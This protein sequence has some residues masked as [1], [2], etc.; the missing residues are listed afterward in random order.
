MDQQLSGA[1]SVPNLSSNRSVG[2]GDHKQHEKHKHKFGFNLAKVFKKNKLGKKN[3]TGKLS[4]PSSPSVSNS[5]LPSTSSVGSSDRSSSPPHSPVPDTTARL[6]DAKTSSHGSPAVTFKV[7]EDELKKKFDT[8]DQQPTMASATTVAPA[9]GD[10]VPLEDKTS[11]L[12]QEKVNDAATE[13]AVV[14]FAG[15]N[16]FC[17]CDC[18]SP[19]RVFS[20]TGHDTW[21]IFYFSG[22]R[23][24][25]YT[26]NWY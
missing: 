8:V 5:Q 24:Y 26:S 19:L 22:S 16:A 20:F 1:K 4:N 25:F 18:P 3:S 9:D 6:P 15:R 14:P 11:A 23:G 7:P 10:V 21:D 13:E 12:N 17:C 2:S